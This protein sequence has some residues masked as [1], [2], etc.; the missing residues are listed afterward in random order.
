M[1]AADI[2]RAARQAG[3]SAAEAVRATAIALA[4]SGGRSDARGDTGIT[5][6]TWGPSVGLM[7]IRTLKG[8]T[9]K[10]TA[11]DI[12][13]LDDPVSNMRA[14]WEI[15]NGGRDWTPWSTFKNGRYSSFL[16]TASAA[17]AKAGSAT[18]TT[19][20]VAVESTV[21]GLD[22]PDLGLG[23]LAGKLGVLVTKG[24]FVS[25][26]LG[27]VGVGVMRAVR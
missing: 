9:G 14:A 24:L 2:Y 5:T 11:R 10:G 13:R 15:S 20:G 3:F 27:L 22:M 8:E 1:T 7:Q 17:A 12:T 21:W 16:A 19:D 6:A 4:E 26:G 18:T 25:L 23:D